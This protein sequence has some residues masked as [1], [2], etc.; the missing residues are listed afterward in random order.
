MSKRPV[1]LTT[2]GAGCAGT[3][4]REKPTLAYMCVVVHTA[5]NTRIA[6]NRTARSDFGDRAAHRPCGVAEGQLALARQSAQ[7][8]LLRRHPW[9]ENGA[10]LD[11]HCRKT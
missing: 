1:G 6:V 8:I 3:R 9:G 11:G 4:F 5:M 10:N 7:S 2:D